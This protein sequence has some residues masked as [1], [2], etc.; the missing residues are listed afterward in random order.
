LDDLTNQ[1]RT[2]EKK[3]EEELPAAPQQTLEPPEETEAE[4][5][6]LDEAE[7]AE[8]EELDDP[9]DPASLGFYPGHPAYQPIDVVVKNTFIELPNPCTP[10]KGTGTS[11]EA[12]A[13]TCPA[14]YALSDEQ[15]REYE[16]A[17]EEAEEAAVQ[18]GA[19]KDGADMVCMDPSCSVGSLLHKAQLCK[20]CAWF[21]H[22]KGCQRASACE[23]C[24]MCPPGEIKRRKKEKT[25]LI[26][27]RRDRGKEDAE[28][29]DRGAISLETTKRS[30]F[31]VH[32]NVG[33]YAPKNA[34]ESPLAGV[35][36]SLSPYPEYPEYDPTFQ[37]SYDMQTIQAQ[38][39]TAFP[40]QMPMNAHYPFP[41]G[42]DYSDY[43]FSYW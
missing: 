32:D 19:R 36:P 42:A 38:F 35:L 1:R 22:P 6:E 23:F 28:P 14:K 2:A 20:P 17:K 26:R 40:P 41:T 25:M 4:P 18:F 9:D 37:M 30:Q 8:D 12:I 43:G 31:G 33:M 10:E 24:H 29:S 5:E 11:K 34:R 27:K 21:H 3:R 16:E 15:R 39:G 7:D 13:A